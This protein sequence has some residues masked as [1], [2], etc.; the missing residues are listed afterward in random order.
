MTVKWVVLILGF[1][2]VMAVFAIFVEAEE[3]E[4]HEISRRRFKDLVLSL[5]FI[6]ALLLLVFWYVQG[7]SRP[8]EPDYPSSQRNSGRATP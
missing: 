6:V 1:L 8:K 2:V 4:H 3:Y 7:L 5:M